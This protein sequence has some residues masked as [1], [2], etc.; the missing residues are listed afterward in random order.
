MEIRALVVDDDDLV[1]QAVQTAVTLAVAQEHPFKKPS[2]DGCAGPGPDLED[3]IARNSYDLAVVDM[4]LIGG[5]GFDVLRALQPTD[6]LCET[7]VVVYSALSEYQ[8]LDTALQ[9]LRLG[10]FTFVRK[11]GGGDELGAELRRTL[12]AIW[13]ERSRAMVGK[14]VDGKLRKMLADPR[15]MERLREGL[16]VDKGF[17]FCDI[18]GS[19]PFIKELQASIAGQSLVGPV[20]RE[21]LSWIGDILQSRGGIVDKFIG[22]EV[23]A[24]FRDSMDTECASDNEACQICDAMV[25][26]AL[27][28]RE[29][30][31]D[32]V[33]RV[34]KKLKVRHRPK[35]LPW[36]KCVIN[37]DKVIWAVLGSE[38]YLDLTILTD[39]VVRTAR[40]MQ[41]IEKRQK[42]VSGGDIYVLEGVWQA[43][44]RKRF[45]VEDP[46]K[47]QLRDFGGETIEVCRID[48]YGPGRVSRGTRKDGG[49]GAPM[50]A[51]VS[52]SVGR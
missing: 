50:R 52:K 21:L 18:T 10:A 1:R 48:G 33:D 19:T 35:T 45:K 44:T 40:V 9:A 13:L 47:I 31:R 37:Y 20:I 15:T 7:K 51:G 11:G 27:E 16:T 4:R 39:A 30:F 2:V 34:F 8:A 5:T 26:A 24:Y 23:M 42:F 6:P 38:Q 17:L 43:L 41:H 14:F 29:G 36:V 32:Q 25:D 49:R 28:I 12:K 3:L 22:D 46:K